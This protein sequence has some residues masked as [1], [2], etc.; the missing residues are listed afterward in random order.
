M[1][2][3]MDTNNKLEMNT[4]SKRND[5][6][7]KQTLKEVDRGGE[8]TP[9]SICF[10][11]QVN[12]YKVQFS[13]PKCSAD[14]TAFF[15]KQLSI[16][17]GIS[18]EILENGGLK[19]LPTIVSAGKLIL[20]VSGFRFDSGELAKISNQ[21]ALETVER[22]QRIDL[23]EK[24]KKEYERKLKESSDEINRRDEKIRDV[25]NRYEKLESEY[26][27]LKTKVSSSPVLK[28]AL[29]QVELLEDLEASFPEQ[30]FE[31][32]SKKGYGDVL[33][34]NILI[35]IG[36]W[37]ESNVG[38]VIDSKNKGSIVESDIEKLRRDMKFGK[39]EIGLIIATKQEQLRMKEMPCGVYR[40]EE[41]YI[42]VTSRENLNHHIA[43]RFTRDILG[44]LI[45]E[46]RMN[47]EEKVI[48]VSK[49]N[50]IIDDISKAS[51][52]HKK[53]R[54]KA[55]GIIKDVDSE[56]DYLKIKFQEAWKVLGLD[57]DVTSHQVKLCQ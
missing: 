23:E 9:S 17:T 20:E 24:A 51:E 22:L 37:V 13:C 27:E 15:K 2:E 25:E 43:M 26:E 35:N 29:A 47:K 42:L 28:G 57:S 45:Y 3:T 53:I 41:G 44:R 39:K 6:D 4:S 56:E 49:L 32:I 1:G 16:T 30:H 46:L 10:K 21:M 19:T 48:D 7:E 36:K 52:Y 5:S 14:L 54:Q 40:S 31:D 55:E 34:E 8:I 11:E 33:L 18:E 12:D 38:A 50:S